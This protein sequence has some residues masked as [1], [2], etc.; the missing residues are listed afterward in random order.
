MSPFRFKAQ[1]A[2]LAL[3]IA[4]AAPATPGGPASVPI[5]VPVATPEVERAESAPPPV[6][7][8]PQEELALGL[9]AEAAAGG[10]G[11]PSR[12]RRTFDPRLGEFLRVG[13]ALGAV[14]A[15]LLL[16]RVMLRRMAGPLA[17]G[18][19]PSG[20]LE[21]LARYPVARGQQLVLL[22]MS[23]RI[24]LLHQS[25]AG[26]TALSEVTDPDEVAQL[27]ARVESGSGPGG[28][29][30]PPLL[31]RLLARTP[32]SED[33]TFVRALGRRSEIDGKEIV[34]LTRRTRR[35]RA[36]REAVR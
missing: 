2:V 29:G 13:G 4:P 35:R 15:L 8:P 24:V 31:D 1:S 12:A 27:L 7:A 10:P 33:E 11:Q 30:F 9:P 19:R 23:G 36:A 16:T 32:R 5:S 25:K 18:R 17:G 28:P 6:A 14:L 21:V 20:V 26:M 34:D 3:L 22:K